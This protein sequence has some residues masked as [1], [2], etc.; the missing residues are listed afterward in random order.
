[1]KLNIIDDNAPEPQRQGWDPSHPDWCPAKDLP[2]LLLARGITNPV[3]VEIGVDKGATSEY[4]IKSIPGSFLYG[5]DP[6]VDY[7]DWWGYV[8]WSDQAYS[9]MRQRLDQYRDNGQFK[10]YRVTSDD[11]ANLFKDE[12]LDFIFIDGLHTY[13]QVLLDCKH[14]YPKL[15]RGGLCSGHDYTSVDGV[16]KAAREYAASVGKE[17]NNCLQDVWFW[18]KD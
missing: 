14:Y 15:K 8:S 9:H 6:Y 16:G 2:S 7:Q 3:G 1:M 17:I 18:W 4:L 12:T 11:G 13:E 10:L 5:V